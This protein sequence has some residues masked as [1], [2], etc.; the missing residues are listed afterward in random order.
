MRR[1]E[2]AG[3]LGSQSQDPPLGKASLAQNLVEALP[4][5]FSM[6]R[7]STPSCESKS[8]TATRLRCAR[9]AIARASCWKR[10]A[11]HRSQAF[12]GEHLDRDVTV[13]VLVASEVDHPHAS[14][15][16]LSEDQ[17][18][19]VALLRDGGLAHRG[20]TRPP[21]ATLETD[22]E[23]RQRSRPTSGEPTNSCWR[24][25]K[26]FSAVNVR[27]V[28]ERSDPTPNRRPSQSIGRDGPRV[29]I[30]KFSHGD[31]NRPDRAPRAGDRGL[32]SDSGPPALERRR[33]DAGSPSCAR[34]GAS[35]RGRSGCCRSRSRSGCTPPR[36]GRFP[37][38]RIPDG[39]RA[40]V[41]L[42]RMP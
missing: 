25:S 24:S 2:T 28:A 6:T 10:G 15:P 36:S 42:A 39:L 26:R 19:G 12:R 27:D 22:P 21:G 4:S 31:M 41:V 29:Q 32:G 3:E 18:V 8:R 11:R 1:R 35:R 23:P 37:E 16:D 40:V 5:T 14:G 20:R 30:P 13:E 38:E 34:P 33:P 9:L 17:V 7:K